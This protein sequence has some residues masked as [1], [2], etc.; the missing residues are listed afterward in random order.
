MKHA[1]RQ[2][3][4]TP[5]FTAVA[6]LTLALGIATV[7]TVFAIVDEVALR[8]ARNP[9]DP[10]VYFLHST[11]PG[12]QIPDYESIAAARPLGVEA[13]AAY[14]AVG[15]LAQVPGR[16]ERING[17]R[18][19]GQYAAVHA[20]RAQVGRWINDDDNVGGES[21]PTVEARG[22]RYPIVRGT[23]GADVAVISDRLWREWFDADRTVVEGGTLRLDGRHVRIVGV[24]PPGF[25]T[26]IDIWQPFGTRRLLTRAELDDIAKGLAM[27][28]FPPNQPRPT[29]QQPIVQAQ[30]RLAPGATV[31]GISDRLT[32]ITSA[33]PDTIEMPRNAV[34]LVPRLGNDRNVSTGYTILI[35]AALV[36][37]AACANLGNM[38][39]GRAMEREGEFATRLALGASR[40]DIAAI[41]FGETIIVAAAGTAIGLGIAV[42]GLELFENAVPAFQITSWQRVRLDLGLDWRVF[43]FASAAGAVASLIV[44]T[45]AIWRSSKAPLLVRLSAAGPAVLSRTEGRTLRTMLVAV[46]VSAAV[47]LLIATGLLLENTSKQLDRRL[48][49]DTDGLIA[50][51]IEL[52]DSY[53]PSRGVHF[54]DRLLDD[55]Q[56]T[57][58]IESAA[59]AD[60]LPGGETPAPRISRAAITAD[61]PQTTPAGVQIRIDG[62]WLLASPGFINTLGLTS[63]GRD[64]D[65]RDLDGTNPVAI[66]SQSV[67]RQFW[68]NG[69]ALGQRLI[70]C[71]ERYKRIIVGVVADPVVSRGTAQPMTVADAIQIDTAIS[72]YVFL[73]AAQHYQPDML[74]VIRTS[75]PDAS[76]DALRRAVAAI[77]ADVPLFLAGRV[78]ATQFARASSERAV[79]T[80]AGALAAIALGITILGVSAVVSYFVSRRTREFG[81]RL[82][83]GASRRQVVKLVIDYSIHMTLIGLLPGVLFASLGTNIFQAE[84]RKLR[85]N[86]IT[87][88]V[89]VPLLLLACALIAAYIPA[90]RAARV[91]PMK[92]LKEL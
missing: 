62:R 4:G 84:L 69:D 86:G 43:G 53:D 44:G 90:R 42:A 66:V 10:L 26:A 18:V 75:R 34:R 67:A 13:V 45:G 48:Q 35:F 24:A 37:V 83:L 91:E 74:V 82:A 27:R 92:T 23:L 38:M 76:V 81:L 77:D 41:L 78:H 60:A 12:L 39:Y 72:N 22:T 52:P 14:A 20:V 70:C 65:A 36:F 57:G 2:L 5:S 8:P 59:I 1:L 19:S 29:P 9:G 25:E 31:R 3:A 7:T 28:P 68:P 30:A 50:A 40:R 46:Q 58:Q 80:L 55:L 49:F 47:L 15:G 64:F 71:G 54:F 32:A 16:A 11:G 61:P 21:D 63:T 6:I 51:R 89:F 73:P 85:P 88:W 17:W 87:M 56:A 79:R 33:R